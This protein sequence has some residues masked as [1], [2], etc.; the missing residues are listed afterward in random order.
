[1]KSYIRCDIDFLDKIQKGI[2][3]S[4]TLLTLD[5][6]SMYTNIDNQL[7]L[8]AITYWLSKTL[9]FYQEIYQKIL[10]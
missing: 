7:G 1:M 10:S 6:T 5:V 8:E 3:A 9:A 2:E 4:E